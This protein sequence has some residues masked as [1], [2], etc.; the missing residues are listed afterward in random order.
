M[1]T[2]A[3]VGAGSQLGAAVA[4]R[5]AR[6]GFAVALISRT[7]ERVEAVAEELRGEGINARAYA[8]NVK[9]RPALREAL[10]AAAAELGAITALQYSPLPAREFM[11]PILETTVEDLQSAIEFSVYGALTAAHHVLQNMRFMGGGTI[12]FVNG[13][14]AVRPL[15]KFGGTSVA[16]HGE[17][18]LGA[19]LHEALEPDNIHVG[20]LVIPGGIIAGHPRKDPVALAE[21]LWSMH[22]ERGEFRVFAGDM[23][24]DG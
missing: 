19:A 9:D 22:T 23:D 20:Q 17:S 2:L 18:A 11:R 5:F 12:I 4:R 24:A 3:I 1:P 16:F 14:T 15:A 13:G 8:A 10:D 21:K 6:E 7:A